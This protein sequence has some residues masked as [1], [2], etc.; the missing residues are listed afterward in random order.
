M[1]AVLVAGALASGCL[2]GKRAPQIR[3][4]TVAV[5]TTETRLPFGV[6]V[7]NFGAAPPYRSTRIALRRSR[8]RLDYYDFNR[9]AANPQSLLAGAVQN[10][11]DRIGKPNDPNPIVVSGFIE[12]LEAVTIEGGLRGVVNLAL[13]GQRGDQVLLQ[14]SYTE[15][16]P[17]EGDDPEDVVAALSTALDRILGQFAADLVRA[18]E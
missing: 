14:R 4:Y 16:V 9:W 17:V 11:F 5:G 1:L 18:V 15:K 10:Y 2:G 7:G 13:A 6:R 12:R 8:Y 3:Y